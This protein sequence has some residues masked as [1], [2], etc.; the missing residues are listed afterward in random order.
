[1]AIQASNGNGSSGVRVIVSVRSLINS[2]S[3]SKVRRAFL[4]VKAKRHEIDLELTD[5]LIAQACGVSVAY[6]H[7]AE[8]CTPQEETLIVREFRPLIQ[9]RG[10]KPASVVTETDDELDKIARR[11][12][13][14]RLWDALQRSL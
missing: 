6:M 11:C 8:K 1:M 14:E 12:G 13:P 4:A 3:L 9:P 2:K 10:K 7:A 5:K